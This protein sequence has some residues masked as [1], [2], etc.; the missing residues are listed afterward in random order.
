MKKEFAREWSVI[1]SFLLAAAWFFF[2]IGK[3][4]GGSLLFSMRLA[5]P[6]IVLAVGSLW[7]R[8]KWMMMAFWFC[9]LGDAMGVLGSFEGQM[10]GFALAHICF[11][12]YFIIYIRKGNAQ[13]V[14]MVAVSSVCLI[15]LLIAAWKVI[16][17]VQFLP[18]RIGCSV[19]AL[20]L[21]GTVWTSAV[22][23]FS[24]CD[25]RKVFPLLA[26]LGGVSFLVSDFV[27]AWNKFTEHI[28]NASL[29]I[30][31]T[32]YAALL[33]LFVGSCNFS[34]KKT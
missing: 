11:I 18:I 15:P 14:V 4:E 23:A 16:P 7:Q 6:A 28:P 29:C 13:P 22:R 30:M 27:L 2:P 32:Y 19:Y 10:G 34:S 33:L 9:A 5:L 17:A 25:G 8:P 12:L 21:I 3:P 24:V 31:T 26:A 20:L 1:V